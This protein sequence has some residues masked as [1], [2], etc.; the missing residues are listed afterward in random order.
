MPTVAPLL[1]LVPQSEIKNVHFATTL[2]IT[3]REFSL[4]SFAPLHRRA[5]PHVCVVCA[6][7]WITIGVRNQSIT[8]KECTT[9]L[10]RVLRNVSIP[11][12]LNVQLDS[13][14]WSETN[15]LRQYIIYLRFSYRRKTKRSISNIE[16]CADAFF[17]FYRRSRHN[18]V[19]AILWRR[20][21][22]RL[23]GLTETWLLSL[24][25]M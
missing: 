5:A 15:L 21:A 2:I 11:M 7:V 10:H 4:F 18:R 9:Y 20:H 25:L 6:C 12:V 23:S 13:S 22:S 24:D 16:Y 19:R 17:L 1:L 3:V 8:N 14:R